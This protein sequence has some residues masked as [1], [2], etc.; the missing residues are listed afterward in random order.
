MLNRL[1]DTLGTPVCLFIENFLLL[2]KPFSAEVGGSAFLSVV[3][4]I[5]SKFRY[6]V[7]RYEAQISQTEAATWKP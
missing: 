3:E 5:L 4:A 7:L 6:P 1:V 2:N